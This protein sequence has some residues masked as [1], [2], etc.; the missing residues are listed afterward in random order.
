M[1]IKDFEHV[2]GFVCR[3]LKRKNNYINDYKVERVS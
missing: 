1:N 3:K 2:K